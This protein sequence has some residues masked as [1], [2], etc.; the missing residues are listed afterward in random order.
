M[1]DALAQRKSSVK[2]AFSLGDF[3]NHRQNG[4]H[5]RRTLFLVDTKI[6]CQLVYLNCGKQPIAQSAANY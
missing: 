2:V 1:H 4:T 5:S 3:S 6:L